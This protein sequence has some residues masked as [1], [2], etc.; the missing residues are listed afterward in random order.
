MWLALITVFSIPFG[1][2]YGQECTILEAKQPYVM[3]LS[4]AIDVNLD[5]VEPV[6]LPVVFHVI[7]K[8]EGDVTNISDQQVLSQIP[9]LDTGFR[10]GPGVDTKIQFC[11]ASRDPDGNPTNGITRHNGVSLFG[12]EYA[13][14]GVA[15]TS[16]QNGV[17]DQVMKEATGCWNPD[18]YINIYVVSEI[19]GNDADNGVQAYAYLNPTGDCRDGIVQLYNT[20]GTTGVVKEGKTLGKTCVHEMGHYLSLFHTFTNSNGCFESNCEAQGD[21]VCDTPPTSSNEGC[22]TLSSGCEDAMIENFMDYTSE[23]CKYSFTV[24]QAER[25]HGQLQTIRTDLTDNFSCIAPVDYD[26]AVTSAVYQETWCRDFQDIAI[27]ISNQGSQLTSIAE[28]QI[29]CSG[30]VYS[31]TVFDLPA[32]ESV[33]V[34]FEDVLVVGADSFQAQVISDLDQYSSNNTS[35]WPVQIIEGDLLTIDVHKDFLGCVDFQFFDPSGEILVEGDYGHG[36]V[37]YTYNICVYDG[38]YTVASQDCAGDGF[39]TFDA[40]DDGVC[41]YGSEGIVGAIGQD[42]VFA[43]GWGLE[44]EEWQRE[45][46]NIVSQCSMDYN[47]DGYIGTQDIIELMTYFGCVGS[48][49]NDPNNDQNVNVQDLLIILASVGPCLEG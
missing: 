1:E 48:C 11:L 49:Y 42:T 36:V 9:A 43:T 10:W 12:E 17:N 19:G 32:G 20:T 28:V 15:N 45:W 3:G 2:V 29:E 25:M 8:G 26:V 13:E 41:D 31:E 44:F 40:G 5:Q 33:D 4:K 47:G 34:L 39:C 24:G 6:T 18:E 37:T 21:E 22:S 7:H 30:Q 14:N 23:T 38:C 16:V 35:Y 27:T 46:C